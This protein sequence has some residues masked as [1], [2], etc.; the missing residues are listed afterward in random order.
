MSSLITYHEFKK[1]LTSCGFSAPNE[2]TFHNFMAAVTYADIESKDELAKFLA[3]LLH[4][5]G[6]LR[7]RE[8]TGLRWQKPQAL[9]KV[10]R[11]DQTSL[12]MAEDTF[13][14]P[15]STITVPHPKTSSV[16]RTFCSITP[17]EWPTKKVWHSRTAG[18]FWKD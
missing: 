11:A 12:I 9:M 18:W 17:K 15:M 10:I 3:H 6:G 16:T 7:Y 4:E 14:S 13:S 8:E 1:A 5:S 2:S